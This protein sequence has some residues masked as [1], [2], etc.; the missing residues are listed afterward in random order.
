[1]RF[2]ALA[3][4]AIASLSAQSVITG[5]VSGPVGPLDR[6]QIRV[7]SGSDGPVQEFTTKADGA[8]S[9]TV[10]PGT[11]DVFAA[12]I[13]YNA[14][15]KRGVAVAPGAKVKLDFTMANLSNE[16]VPGEFS[17]LELRGRTAEIT[18]A[19]PRTSDGKPDL[20]GVWLPGFPLEQDDPIMKPAAAAQ[21]KKNAATTGGADPRAHCLPSGVPR[22]NNADLTRFVQT[23]DM[24]I[25]LVEGAP[26]G[27]RQVFMNP[28]TKHP[29]PN[30][31]IP[32]WM[33]HSIGR[34]DGDTLV[35]D[36]VGFHDRGWID[37]AG[38]PQTEQLHV[39]ERFHRIDLG[40]MELQVTIDDPGAYE[41]P[42]G[43]RRELKLAAPGDELHE[44]VCNEN[45][46]PEHFVG[47]K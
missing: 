35:I 10:A 44:Y 18:G 36:T 28:A 5:I 2:A 31:W 24:L 47:N 1:M 30:E 22:T 9:F 32:S 45:E 13:S 43:F 20:S 42:W 14:F 26:P 34:W 46:K 16:G 8:F 21:Q 12:K 27:F 15:T 19:L 7:R 39:I 11:Y 40:T 33:G 25:I 17:F 4:W 37:G 41:K 6:V 29:D 3:V 23:K 38:R